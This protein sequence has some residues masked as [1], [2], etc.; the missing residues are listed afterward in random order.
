MVPQVLARLHLL[1]TDASRSRAFA[2]YGIVYGTTAQIG[3]AAG[4]AAIGA[5]FFAVEALQSA[6]AGFLVSLVLFVTLIMICAAFPAW[7]RLAS[8]RS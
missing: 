8:A 6:R 7:M 4:V 3:N 5:V 2:I 1:F